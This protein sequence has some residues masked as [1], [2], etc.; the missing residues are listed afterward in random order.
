[1]RGLRKSYVDVPDGQI[2]VRRMEADAPFVVFLHQTA[3]SGEMWAKVMERL[4]GRWDL[5]ALDTPGFGGSFDPDPDSEPSMDDYVGWIGG[6]LDALGI[7]RCHLV[8]HHTGS[9]IAVQLA[10]TRPALS[11]SVTLFGPA[12]LRPDEREEAS[13]SYGAV[14]EPTASG[15]YLLD[16]WDYLRKLG[17]T[18]DPLLAN[19]EMALQL[20]AWR[21]RVQAYA[22]MW[23]QDFAGLYQQLRCPVMIAAAPDDLLYPFLDRAKS[24]QPDAELL[25]VSGGAFEPDLDAE[26]VATGLAS[27]FTMHDPS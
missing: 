4:A 13:K 2:H 17:A 23:K 21:G 11:G 1:M 25:A 26:A 19:R 20:R 7:T 6:A 14:F 8:G 16:N 10:A 9:A 12:P 27:F 24:M 18:A 5:I 22:A 3:S 15:G